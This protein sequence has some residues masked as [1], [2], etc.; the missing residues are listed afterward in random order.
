V[1]LKQQQWSGNS[2]GFCMIACPSRVVKFDSCVCVD[3]EHACKS[4][5]GNPHKDCKTLTFLLCVQVRQTG[6]ESGTYPVVT[7]EGKQKGTLRLTLT[8]S[9]ASP[10]HIQVRS[11]IR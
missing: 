8:Y 9:A 4:H 11:T 6:H 3:R 1:L 2:D 10:G 5:Q 7:A